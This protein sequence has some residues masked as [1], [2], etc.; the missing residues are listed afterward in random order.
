[1]AEQIE[2]AASH[3]SPVPRFCYAWDDLA[4]DDLCGCLEVPRFLVVAITV[5]LMH[6]RPISGGQGYGVVILWNQ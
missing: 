6:G 1:M 3:G 2:R 4:W 5:V